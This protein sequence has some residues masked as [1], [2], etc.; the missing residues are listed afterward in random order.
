MLRYCF[1]Q[2][3]YDTNL[4]KPTYLGKKKTIRYKC[5]ICGNTHD[6][7]DAWTDEKKL[8]VQAEMDAHHNEHFM[9]FL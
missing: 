4:S 9:L 5:L 2:D 3:V 7:D 6:Y 1:T 8:E